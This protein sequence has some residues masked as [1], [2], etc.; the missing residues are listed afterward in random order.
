MTKDDIAARDLLWTRTTI[1]VLSGV[2][3]I[4]L[5]LLGVAVPARLVDVLGT[6]IILGAS[7]FAVGGLLGFLFGIPR[8]PQTNDVGQGNKQS[9]SGGMVAAGFRHNTNLEQI[10]DWLTKILVGVSLTQIEPIWKGMKESAIAIEKASGLSQPAAL[11]VMALYA[12]AGFLAG[13]LFTA[14]FLGGAFERAAQAAQLIAPQDLKAL[15]NS[16]V[17][18]SELGRPAIQSAEAAESA[19]TVRKVALND[20]TSAEELLAWARAQIAGGNYN[21]AAEAYQ[22][23]LGRKPD[24]PQ[25]RREYA[26]AL[27]GAKEYASALLE[28][29]KARERATSKA[30]R[31][32]ILLDLM[33][34]CLYL[35]A[36]TG[37]QRGLALVEEY[38][39]EGGDTTNARFW[40]YRACALG[41]W[42]KW[43]KAQEGSSPEL[44]SR[45]RDEALAA[46][47][48]ALRYDPSWKDTL[49]SLLE[50]ADP[51]ENDLDG[52]KGDA[53]FRTLLT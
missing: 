27:A 28:L 4:G 24:D 33:F 44:L 16:P 37:F 47:E 1:L 29:E 39:R 41:Q 8:G 42:Y 38:E 12:V 45:I 51:D 22:R 18:L 43:Q 30:E 7:S 52:F 48:Q 53:A 23:A 14:L 32:N 49:R 26:V 36:P 50:G 5:F 11:S 35:D 40:V 21:A 25:L 19:K 2:G 17:Q 34:N 46:V 3:F 10:S 31:E 9:V 15:A 13:Y 6:G 20:L